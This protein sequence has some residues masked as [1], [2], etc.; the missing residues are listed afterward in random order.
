MKI[1][2][3]YP[4]GKDENWQ[5]VLQHPD[6]SKSKL[7]CT[8]EY[9]LA[10]GERIQCKT[11]KERKTR[12]E[13]ET[14][15]HF[16]GDLN[17]VR[18][19]LADRPD[20]EIVRNRIALIDAEADPRPGFAHKE[21]C[22]ILSLCIVAEDTGEMWTGV[23][24]DDSDEAEKALLSEFWTH[25]RGFTTICSWNLGDDYST[26]GYDGPLLRA[27][28]C[29]IWPELKYRFN[30]F[31]WQDMLPAYK[32]L[33]FTESGEEKASYALDA[34]AKFELGEGKADFDS[35]KCWEEWSAG[36]TRRAR[37]VSY[38]ERDTQI[39]FELEKKTE[40]LRLAHTICATC[41]VL[42][43][44]MGLLPTTFVDGFLL[45][46]G[47]QRGQR[48]KTKV[49][50]ED[51]KKKNFEG[52]YVRLPEARGILHDVMILDANS[53]YPSII[54]SGNYSPEMKGRTGCVAPI[55]GV[56]FATEEEGILPAA[57]RELMVEKARLKKVYKSLPSG[58]PEF[59]DAFNKH[60]SFKAILNS[61]FGVMGAMSSP[62]FDLEIA[63]SITLTGQFFLKSAE[64]AAISRGYTPIAA[65]TDS[66]M[67]S[68]VS[69]EEFHKFIAYVNDELFPSLAKNHRFRENHLRVA[70]D[71]HY[72]RAVWGLKDDGTPAKKKYAARWADSDEYDVKGFE[73]KR[74][75]ASPLARQL[76]EKCIRKLMLDRSESP[77][78]FPAIII[79]ARNR[80]LNEP[81]PREEIVCSEAIKKKLEEYEG[82]SPA[83]SVARLM[84]E[85]GEEVQEG[86]K[87]RFIVTDGSVSPVVAIPEADYVEGCADVFY[88]WERQVFPPTKRLLMGAFPTYNWDQF[89]N[90]RPVITNAQRK[91]TI[92]EIR[93]QQRLRGL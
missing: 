58:S 7:P 24:K 69:L 64:A 39:L 26:R 28:S 30:R 52:G 44:T 31:L 72:E 70:F 42:P 83:L 91:Q 43:D 61:F 15:P 1:L 88:V 81:L 13:A 48:R 22:R 4:G 21:D 47:S 14:R 23:L 32:R 56:A 41:G 87:I 27:R 90:V 33:R 74:G 40:I 59:I 20:I 62:W 89:E 9:F 50:R 37:M 29:R 53:L 25:M 11:W 34:I 67:L 73:V 2:H 35:R 78:D 3:A 60:N 51:T 71:K 82:T 79:Q 76:Q 8:Y 92:L 93:G 85:R 80:I 77:D 57:C 17:P 86:T 66:L 5:L 16:E 46:L 6:G 18:R 84:V 10:G 12:L 68:G 36:G 65:D 75:D 19:L 54:R 49:W 38:M 45:R 55:T 63:S